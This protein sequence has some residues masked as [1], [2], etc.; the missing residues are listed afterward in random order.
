MG[1]VIS[2]SAAPAALGPYSQAIRAG[3]FIFTAGQLG[4]DPATGA[5]REGVAA[6]AEQA[7]DNLAAVLAQGGA[8]FSDVVKSTIFFADLADF[9]TVD[10]LYGARFPG[11]APARSAVQVA[12]LPKNGLV[13]I[14]MV[15]YGPR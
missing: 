5:L 11:V 10:A 3:D 9:Q 8:R 14:E 6:Q 4:I 13:E 12:A 1:E 7:L 15:A 2:T